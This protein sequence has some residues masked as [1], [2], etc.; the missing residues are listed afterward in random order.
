VRYC[1]S[2][3]ISYRVTCKNPPLFSLPPGRAPDL[4]LRDL[5]L[6]LRLGDASGSGSG[7]G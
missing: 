6:R 5:G 7:S 2:V 1:K 4:R 3:Y